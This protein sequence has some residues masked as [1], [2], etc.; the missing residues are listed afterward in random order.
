MIKT[1]RARA[2]F[3]ASFKD[4]PFHRRGAPRFAPVVIQ[5]VADDQRG[6]ARFP[7]GGLRAWAFGGLRAKMELERRIGRVGADGESM[8]STS[9]AEQ[10]SAFMA[11]YGFAA[12]SARAFL[13]TSSMETSAPFRRLLSSAASMKA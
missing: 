4:R 1:P 8:A 13:S 10:R 6:L 7:G 2:A 5:H 3:T 9:A 12:A 11:G